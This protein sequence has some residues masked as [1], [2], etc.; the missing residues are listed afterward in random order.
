M[1]YLIHKAC[2]L[3]IV[4]FIKIDEACYC[5]NIQNYCRVGTAHPTYLKTWKAVK[6]APTNYR[7]NFS[8]YLELETLLLILYPTPMMPKSNPRKLEGSGTL[9]DA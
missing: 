5:W 1:F 3:L 8:A 4:F 7:A 2:V 9:T 6:P